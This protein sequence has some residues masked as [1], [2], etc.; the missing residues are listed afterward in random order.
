MVNDYSA[1]SLAEMRSVAQSIMAQISAP[2]TIGLSG[3]LGAGK[4]TFVKFLVKA[5]GGD[6]KEVSSPTFVL[7][8]RYQT[9]SLLIDH[10]DLYRIDRVPD[11]LR[12][13]NDLGMVRLIEWGEKLL[14]FPTELDIVIDIDFAPELGPEGRRVQIKGLEGG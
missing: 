11:E 5:F 3:P 1:A 12:E 8:Q 6:E 7:Q 9:P 4:T 10:W 2:L 14:S 13:A